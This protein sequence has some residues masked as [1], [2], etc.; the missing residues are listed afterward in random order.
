[1]GNIPWRFESSRV[2]N[3]LNLKLKKKVIIIGSGFSSLSASCYLA[4]AGF[5][6]SVYEKN[7]DFGGRARQFKEKGFTFDM[8]P[9]WYW[10]CLLYT[11]PS[12]R[13]KRQS[14]MPS[15]A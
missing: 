12:P 14:R 4:K 9:S 11:S 7:L 8:G 1:M 3:H 13:D 5:D 6:V 15:S 2:H 10:I